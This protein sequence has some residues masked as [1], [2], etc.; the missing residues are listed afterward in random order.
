[1]A[2]QR[3]RRPRAAL[4]R[5]LRARPPTPRQGTRPALVRRAMPADPI[6]SDHFETLLATLSWLRD[7]LRA[8]DRQLA[9]IARADD[10]CRLLMTTPGVVPITALAFSGTVE[11]PGRFRAI[12]R[13]R[14]VSC[15]DTAAIPV[16]RGRPRRTDLQMRRSV[17]ASPALRGGKRHH[18][19]EAGRPRRPRM[20]QP[21]R[22]PI[23]KLEGAGC[24]GSEA[25]DDPLRH[26]ARR[27]AVPS[28]G[29]IFTTK[30]HP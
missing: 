23:R 20:G 21:D 5:R 12:E 11:E 10:I 29:L 16:R 17:D 3:H 14:C 27:Y 28:G 26:D 2:A 30:T 6:V 1:M 8:F 9:G 7:R 22:R 4:R 19:S 18:V 13:Y 24:T 15:P 25:G